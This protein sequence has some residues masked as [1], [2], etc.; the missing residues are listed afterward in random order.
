MTSKSALFV[1]CSAVFLSAVSMG[2][3]TSELDNGCRDDL[4]STVAATTTGGTGGNP[5]FV[6]THDETA[7]FPC[8]V[9]DALEKNCQSCHRPGGQG[10]FPLLTYEDTQTWLYG[11]EPTPD[12]PNIRTWARMQSQI[13]PG[14]NAPAMPLGNHP[15]PQEYI[16]RLNA[17]FATCGDNQTANMCERGEGAGGVGGAGGDGGAGGGSGGAGGGGGAG[18]S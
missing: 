17:W 2:S 8:E 12:K 13:Q 15:M 11:R 7:G 4:C 1:V 3:C 18:G 5:G 6:C 10:P 9:Y 16:D 14:A